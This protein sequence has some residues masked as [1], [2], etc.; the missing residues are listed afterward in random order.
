[1]RDELSLRNIKIVDNFI[2]VTTVPAVR[3]GVGFSGSEQAVHPAS[4]AVVTR[5][6]LTGAA[7]SFSIQRS[8][9]DNVPGEPM[10]IVGAGVPANA[11]HCRENQRGGQPYSHPACTRAEPVVQGASLAC[12]PDGKLL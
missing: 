3:A 1:M 8:H 4:G 11:M 6:V 9:F 5:P 2:N 10:S 12:S 7:K